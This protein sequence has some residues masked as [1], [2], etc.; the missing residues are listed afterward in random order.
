MKENNE[1]RHEPNNKHICRGWVR[2]FLLQ[3]ENI[4]VDP[5]IYIFILHQF[6][7]PRGF[8][9]LTLFELVQDLFLVFI[10]L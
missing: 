6:L 8:F 3:E 5:Y 7:S 2:E 10:C 9:L 4:I 1:K